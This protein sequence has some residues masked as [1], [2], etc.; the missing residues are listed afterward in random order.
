MG[1]TTVEA[2]T[3]SALDALDAA[4]D[5]V[6]GA[7]LEPVGSADAVVLVRRLEVAGRRVRALQLDVATRVEQRGL[8]RVD[9]HATVKVFLRHNARLADVEANRRA[10]EVRC[11]RHL[12]AVREA[13]ASGRIGVCHL[14]SIAGAFANTR[15]RTELCELD[16]Q[17]AAMAS[18]QSFL[19]FDRLLSGWVAATDQDGTRDRNDVNH[20]KRKASLTQLADLSW[21][22]RANVGAL[23]GAKMRAMLDVAVEAERQLDWEQA[24]AEHGEGACGEDLARDGGQR[25]ADGLS[26]VFDLAAA[27]HAAAT[28]EQVRTD[29]VIDEA[30]FARELERLAGGHPRA[31]PLDLELDGATGRYR[32][33]TS[34]GFPVEATEAVAAALLGKLRRVVMGAG[35]VVIDL[36]R[37]VRLFTGAAQA[38][39][40]LGHVH[41]Y[42]PGCQVP[43]ST[44]Q[45]D[46][47][48]P[49][50]RG[51]TTSPGNGAPAC[52]R[53]NRFKEC[54]Y[55]VTRSGD[56]RLHTHRPDG[57]ELT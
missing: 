15:V 13:F 53:H 43:T 27:G 50:A 20:Q 39:A 47:L 23:Q 12:P 18:R 5:G 52:G 55:T 57:T 22:L 1:S 34:Q 8:H 54:G 38:A 16:A 29:L 19:E 46:H 11:L 24:R 56:G 45:V 31:R 4:L 6:F 41:C 37:R 36:G 9:G 51:G 42:W 2:V 48:R 33:R 32:C 14:R 21:E 25:A 44:C 49:W 28:G 40:T 26:H 3:T 30:T 10:Q 17:L 7:G 35:S